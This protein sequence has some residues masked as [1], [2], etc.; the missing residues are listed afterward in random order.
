MWVLGPALSDQARGVTP[1]HGPRG[2]RLECAWEVPHCNERSAR[3]QHNIDT[4]IQA[5]ETMHMH[6]DESASLSRGC[7]PTHVDKQVHHVDIGTQK[8]QCNSWHCP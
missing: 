4:R 2:I 8:L 7:V 5:H 6:R 1:P 3:R